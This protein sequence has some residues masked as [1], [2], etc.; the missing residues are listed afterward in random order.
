MR[1]SRLNPRIILLLGVGLTCFQLQAQPDTKTEIHQA[2]IAGDLSTVRMLVEADSTLLESE[3]KNGNTP[4]IA[5][6]RTM[7][8]EVADYLINKGA[9]VNAKGESGTTPLFAVRKRKDGAYSLVQYLLAKGAD[10]NAKMAYSNRNWTVFCDV[11]KT[12]NIKLAKLLIDHDA[13]INIKDI[14]GT[15]LQM[16]IFNLNT[17]MAELLI[18]KG[19]KLQ[20]FSFGNTELHLAAMK[21]CAGLVP[22][23]VAHGANCKCDDRI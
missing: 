16:A 1:N 8:V 15:P 23:L 9:N 4:L 10:V 12:G 17:E 19:A 14:E 18:E 2:I 11:V 5:A 21:G 6:C 13:D 7:Q 20:A 3:D 22:L